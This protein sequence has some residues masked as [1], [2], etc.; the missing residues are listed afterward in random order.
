MS[1]TERQ[2]VGTWRV[3]QQRTFVTHV[4]FTRDRRFVSEGTPQPGTPP[5]HTLTGTWRFNDGVLTV[6]CGS[7]L[8]WTWNTVGFNLGRLIGRDEY[9]EPYSVQTDGPDHIKLA[10][11]SRQSI[12][13]TVTLERL[14]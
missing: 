1:T 3:V 2:L 14:R 11:L 8:P 7:S 9:T 6:S 5:P 13:E 12:G 4:T 10:Q